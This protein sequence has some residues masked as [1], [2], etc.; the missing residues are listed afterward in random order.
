MPDALTATD[1]KRMRTALESIAGFPK[2]AEQTNNRGDFLTGLALAA[3][4]ARVAL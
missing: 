2:A 3:S 4:Y 1:A